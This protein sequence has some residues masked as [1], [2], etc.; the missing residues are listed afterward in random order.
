MYENQFV[1]P[2]KKGAM[3]AGMVPLFIVVWTQRTETSYKAYDI[4]FHLIPP[5]LFLRSFFVHPP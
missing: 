3:P 4:A 5:P 2:K 1:Y